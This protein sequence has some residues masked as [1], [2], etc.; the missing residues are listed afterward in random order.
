MFIRFALATEKNQNP[1]GTFV[2]LWDGLIIHSD[3]FGLRR[4][5]VTEGRFFAPWTSGRRI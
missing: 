4:P 3:Y 1:G 2:R 5:S